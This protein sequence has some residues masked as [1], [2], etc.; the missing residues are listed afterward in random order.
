MSRKT[1]NGPE[2]RLSAWAS[3]V[4]TSGQASIR[5]AARFRVAVVRPE[6]ATYR[7]N[8]SGVTVTGA[9][10]VGKTRVGLHV[11]SLLLEAHPSGVWTVELAPLEDPALVAAR[12]ARTL[13]IA[14]PSNAEPLATL[15]TRLKRQTMLLVLDNCEHLIAEVAWVADTL[16]RSCPHVRIIATS[17]EP[18]KVAGERSFRLPSLRFPAL[19]APRALGAAESS[20]Y[21]AVA[22]FVER[23]QGVDD[24]FEL[25]DG[26]APAVAEI[27]RRLDGIPL[28][29]ELAAAR[30]N[31]LSPAALAGMLDRR[32]GILM[33]S[34]ATMRDDR[35]FEEARLV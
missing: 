29:L 2:R 7:A 13:E 3:T 25:S 6:P 11:A 16:L 20:A 5:S 24:R 4:A 1:S 14:P 33:A 8:R 21:D 35:A 9:G 10:G 31:A 26:N 30:V 32:L 15:V 23:V 34:R 12:I 22:L 18:L 19:E 28:A 27:C 17:R